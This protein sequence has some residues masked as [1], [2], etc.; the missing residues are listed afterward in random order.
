MLSLVLSALIA[1][2]AVQ[3]TE[4]QFRSPGGV[5]E[6][7]V[8]LTRMPNGNYSLKD[9]EAEKAF[10]SVDFYANDVALCA[11]TWSTS[12]GTMIYKTEGLAQAQ[13]EATRCAGKTGHDKIAKFKNTLNS[14]KTSS[15]FSTSA[16]LYYHFSR[17]FDTS[18][19]VP[20]AV[21]RSID[22]AQHLARVSSKAV[23]VS[24]MNIAGWS[25]M[26]DAEKNPATY[27]PTDEL[28]T[29]DRSQIFGVIFK[30]KGNM[31]GAELE[32]TEQRPWGIGQNLDFQQTPGY[33]ALRS[34][35]PLAQAVQEGITNAIKDP[36]MKKAIGT[37]QPAQVVYWMKEL[38]EI[39]LLDYIFSQQDRI[40]NIDFVWEWAYVDASGDVKTLRVKDKKFEDL[41]RSRMAS[42][43][44]PP[45][46]ATLKPILLER[47]AI[48][49]NDAGGRVQYTNFT[50]K[51]QHL[52]IIRHLNADTYRANVTMCVMP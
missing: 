17:Y 10:C 48:N 30:D 34:N 23:G 38:S 3:G 45:E 46:I 31:S 28:F 35:Q 16:L 32:G 8:A 50:K 39:V 4:T 22:R 12:P 11:K 47:A 15:T 2:A 19:V 40:M 29:A 26:R 7:C 37:V 36:L 6:S 20:T 27:A 33:Y 41:P 43:V 13:Y 51:A 5:T 1:N 25:I 14:E 44:A 9:E 52:E 24:R 49:D 18:V 42:I 21:Y